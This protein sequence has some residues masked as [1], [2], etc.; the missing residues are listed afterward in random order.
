MLHE[1]GCEESAFATVSP[2]VHR[3]PRTGGTLV[4]GLN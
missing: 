3:L 2:D 4:Q 1:Q